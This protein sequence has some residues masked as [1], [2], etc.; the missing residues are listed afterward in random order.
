MISRKT[1]LISYGALV[2][3]CLVSTA[4]AAPLTIE[5]GMPLEVRGVV[6]PVELDLERLGYVTAFRGAALRSAIQGKA[7]PRA[8]AVLGFAAALNPP[9][10]TGWTV[11]T[12]VATSGVFA[13]LIGGLVP[14]S[15]SDAPPGA[16]TTLV[17]S[18][19]VGELGRLDDG[20]RAVQR[21]IE[22]AR[23]V[24]EMDDPAAL[25]FSAR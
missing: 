23:T 8:R 10:L 13:S 6:S 16:T 18:F 19:N 21:V 20:S 5:T 25:L 9:Q 22:G 2:C 11:S 1:D 12:A 3:A 17:S 15:R 7:R 14:S 24:G 4:T